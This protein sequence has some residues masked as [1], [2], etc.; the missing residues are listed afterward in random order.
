MPDLLAMVVPAASSTRTVHVSEDDS[1]AEKRT[2]YEVRT[3]ASGAKILGSAEAY[4][5]WAIWGSCA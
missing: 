3:L 5:S 4:A 1:V 2:G